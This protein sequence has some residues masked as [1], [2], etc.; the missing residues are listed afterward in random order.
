MAICGGTFDDLVKAI[1]YVVDLVG[2]DYVGLG[3]DFDGATRTL[4]SVENLAVL[5][6]A[7]LD[8][9]FNQ[10]EIRKI[11]GMNMQRVLLRNLPS[12]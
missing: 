4:I 5:T 8:G 9:G 12:K 7:L 11:M 10:D 1:K 2:V 3:S 6:Q